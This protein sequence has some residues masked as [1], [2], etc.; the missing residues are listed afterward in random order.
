M[1]KIRAIKDIQG[2]EPK[3]TMVTYKTQRSKKTKMTRD[4]DDIQL[5]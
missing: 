3:G 4:T 1:E 2:I 5:G